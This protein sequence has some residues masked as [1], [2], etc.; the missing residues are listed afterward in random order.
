MATAINKRQ[1]IMLGCIAILVLLI[2]LDNQPKSTS[3]NSSGSFVDTLTGKDIELATKQYKSAMISMQSSQQDKHNLKKLQDMLFKERFSF[4]T[5]T[6]KTSPRSLIQQE[7]GSL[8]RSEAL[9]EIRVSVGSEQSVPNS[10]YL[11]FIDFPVTGIVKTNQVKELSAFV[12]SL[13]KQKKS[14]HWMNC[15]VTAYPP[16]TNET[17]GSLRFNATIRTYILDETAIEL[18]EAPL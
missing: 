9:N 1:K 10:E 15:Q 13:E 11:R 14:Y 12:Q 16:R 4:W 2:I 8:I 17:I 7:I 5:Y 3:S 6:G 18:I